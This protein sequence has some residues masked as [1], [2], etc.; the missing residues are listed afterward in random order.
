MSAADVVVAQLS[1]VR[2]RG[3]GW[4]ARCPA[5]DDKGPS[6]SINE[7]DDGRVL[8][9]CFAG[10]SVHDIT[11][12]IGLTVADLFDRPDWNSETGDLQRANVRR[13]SREADWAAALNVLAIE[14]GV[15]EIAAVGVASGEVL[16]PDDMDRLAVSI[17][18]I[19][20]ARK[21]LNER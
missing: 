17:R 2:Q 10:C 7:G 20:D 9:H 15:V 19:R 11:V 5:H 21:V 16:V 4:E 18:R 1:H 8:L 14:S 13:F 12:A 6:L 3:K